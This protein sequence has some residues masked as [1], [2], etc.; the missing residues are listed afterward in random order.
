M[1]RSTLSEIR[2]HPQ[3]SITL[4][5]GP[6][7]LWWPTQG[8]DGVLRP[9]DIPTPQLIREIQPQAKFLI[10]LANPI[11]RMYSDYY[12]LNDDRKVAKHSPKPKSGGSMRRGVTSS[13]LSPSEKSPAQFHERVIQQ[14]SGFHQCIETILET[15][16]LYQTLTTPSPSSFSSSKTHDSNNNTHVDSPPPGVRKYFPFLTNF[17]NQLSNLISSAA[18][19]ASTTSSSSSQGHLFPF[20]MPPSLI[21]E[22]FRASQI[23][24]HDRHQFGVAGYGRLTIGLYILFIEKWLEHFDS[25][26]FLIVRLENYER[27]PREYMNQIFTFL[28]VSL[29]V[30]ERERGHWDEILTD[31]I[32]N[33]HKYEREEMFDDTERILKEF[34][35]PYNEYLA[36]LLQNRDYLWEDEEN[37]KDKEKDEG[38]REELNEIHQQHPPEEERRQKA[39]KGNLRGRGGGKLGRP[40]APT[41]KVKVN[42][43]PGQGTP[44]KEKETT[45]PETVLITPIPQSFSLENLPMPSSSAQMNE[46][47]ESVMSIPVPSTPTAIRAFEMLCSATLGLDLVALKY[48]LYDYGLPPKIIDPSTDGSGTSPFHCLSAV[49]MFGDANSHSHVFPLLKGEKTWLT[50]LLDPPLPP[51]QAS[52]HSMD[53]KLSLS[54]SINST[55]AWLLAAGAEINIGDHSGHTPL[56]TAAAY[57]L[58]SLVELY[59]LHGGNPNAL[60]H[61]QKT[62]LHYAI[63]YGHSRIGKLLVSYGGN[64]TLRDIHQVTPMDII[65]STGVIS[66]SDALKYFS[67][68]QP[69]VR[70]INRLLHPR[71]PATTSATTNSSNSGAGLQDDE[72]FNGG[73][74]STR[75]S[76]YE[77]DLSCDVDQYFS[78]EITG[79]QLFLEYFARNRPVLIRGLIDSWPVI[80]KYKLDQL[81]TSHGEEIVQ[82]SP[83]PYSSKFGGDGMTTMTMSEYIHGMKLRNLTGGKY[84]WYVFKGNPI[85]TIANEKG[86]LVSTS[87][88]KTP[89]L[90]AEAL[91]YVNMGNGYRKDA[92]L[93]TTELSTLVFS[94]KDFIN[95]QWALG[96]AGTGAPVHFHNT[97]WSPPLCL[98]HSLTPFL[99]LLRN[100]LVYGAKKWVLYPPSDMIMSNRQILEFFETDYL[101]FQKRGF[102]SATC[103]QTAGRP[104][105]LLLLIEQLLLCLPHVGDVLVVPESWGH[106][107]LNIEV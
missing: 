79:K 26:Q 84:P 15:S 42:V 16:P 7:T 78:H 20:K 97:A 44:E 87:D 93:T 100:A 68:V 94:R 28:N 63:A 65:S 99:S 103:V 29:L 38:T 62:P 24:A 86:S 50:D 52:V 56:H 41:E 85:R 47:V 57:G 101:E 58:E 92:T 25:S 59:L 48:L 34:Y 66:S 77:T 91:H 18:S 106:G 73:Y 37:L 53:I 74:N 71:N 17:T 46:F 75:L 14:V 95:A 23:C 36:L 5:G 33:Q 67:V 49:G 3:T 21:H 88:V 30:S 11:H 104:I 98:S 72:R 27:N 43:A 22:W 4:D 9:D 89:K 35:R 69:P 8:A 80:E 64:L 39:L 32:T 61:Q 96:G 13:S 51:L 102:H 83:I 19:S 76:G 70:T 55:F 54:K 81:V 10:T 105:F 12:F 90:I 6:H 1:F 82:V 60:N 45:T 31:R 40:P 107:V 2:E